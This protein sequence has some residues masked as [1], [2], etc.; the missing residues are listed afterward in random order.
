MLGDI[1][2]K[3][4]LNPIFHVE[5][6]VP[7]IGESMS[8]ADHRTSRY[9][10]SVASPAATLPAV[11]R[12]FMYTVFIPANPE[13]MCDL[14]AAQLCRFVGPL[15]LPY[16]TSICDGFPGHVIFRV[17]FVDRDLAFQLLIT[18]LHKLG[19]VAITTKLVLLLVPE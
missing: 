2:F 8:I 9:I 15:A 17:T 1:L 13:S 18:K 6:T 4:R 12:N 5:K 19:P 7:L 16:A 14:V 3:Y 11:S 10:V